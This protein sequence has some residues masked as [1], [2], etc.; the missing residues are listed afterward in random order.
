MILGALA[1]EAGCADRDLA[2]TSSHFASAERQFRFPLT[3]GNQRPQY[4]TGTVT[5]C[6]SWL[7]KRFF[8]HIGQ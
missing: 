1:A 6:G 2:L 8:I 3:Y 7:W 4:T 5:G